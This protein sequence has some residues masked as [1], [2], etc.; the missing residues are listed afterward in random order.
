MSLDVSMDVEENSPWVA[1]QDPIDVRAR[2]VLP[3]KNRSDEISPTIINGVFP[4]VASYWYIFI[5]NGS[6]E[7]YPRYVFSV[8]T[9]HAQVVSVTGRN[10][11]ARTVPWLVPWIG[12]PQ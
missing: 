4:S 7:A 10:F 11:R 5:D 3:L 2:R 12:M 6:K 8:V 1:L 9:R